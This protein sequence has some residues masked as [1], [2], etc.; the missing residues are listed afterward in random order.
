[1]TRLGPGAIDPLDSQDTLWQP[2]PIAPS[3][4]IAQMQVQFRQNGANNSKVSEE[5]QKTI[6]GDVVD[7][8]EHCRHIFMTMSVVLFLPFRQ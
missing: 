1:M 4:T 2:Q 8:I 6:T 5:L 7:G 3:I